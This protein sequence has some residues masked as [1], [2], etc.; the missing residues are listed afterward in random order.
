MS[1]RIIYGTA[2]TGKSTYI[3]QEI[4]EILNRQY[5]NEKEGR[6][7]KNIEANL[8]Q[9]KTPSISIKIITPEQ[10]S[11]TAERKLLDFA[12][13][14]SVLTAEV[15]TFNRMAYRILEEVGGKTKSHLSSSGR[16]MLLD[17]ILLTQKNDF[18]FLG[19]TDENVDMIATQLTELKKHNVSINNLKEITENMK[20]TYLKRK[21]QD[22][23]N[24]YE[25]YT[26]RIQKQ[27]ID[28]NDG[29][30][31]LSERLDDSIQFKNC[32][33]YLD[34]FVGFTL[35]EYAVLRK[36]IKYSKNVTITIC[37]D[38][39]DFNTNPAQDLFYSNKQT[40]ARLIKIANEENIKVEEAI[41]MNLEK[42]QLKTKLEPSNSKTNYSN[43]ASNKA[44]RFHTPELQHLSENMVTPFYTKYEKDVQNLSVF[45]AN[46]PYSE[47]EHV[48]IEITKL[49][50]EKHYRYEEIA[51][52][53]KDIATYGSLCKAIFR[54]Y[55]IPV[56]IDDEKD[57]S[58]NVLVKWMLSLLDIF[59][60][61]WSY[62]AVLGYIKTGFTNLEQYEISLLENY[63]LKWGLKGSKW[64]AKDW[65]FYDESEEE[66]QI[67]LHAKEQIIIPLLQFK[68]QLKGLKTVKQITQ[69]LYKFMLDNHIP[70]ILEEKIAHLQEIGELERANEYTTSWNIVMELLK[71]LIHILGEEQITF[72][73][74]SK[75]I[76]M[77][78]ESSHLGAIPGTADQV[79]MG[80]TDRSRSHKVKAVFIIGLNDGNFPS[81]HKDE[82][83][84]DDKDR[85]I[86]KE[87]GIELAKGTME[88]LYDDQ[89]NIYKAFTT[90]E[91]KLYLS[92]VSSDSEGKSL[93][94]SIMLNKIKRMFPTLH[95]ESDVVERKSEILLKNT[96]FDELL[97][98][99]RK[100]QEGEK[101]EP[102][103]F[104]VYRYYQNYESEKLQQSL[105]ALKYR[106]VPGRLEKANLEKLYSNTLKTSVSKLEQYE[107]CAFSYYLKYGLELKEQN[108]FQV[109]TID[110]GNFMHEVI[111]GFF[112]Y[113][114][115]HQLS[116]KELLAEQIQTVTEEIVA[117]KLTLKKY[118]IFQSIPKYRTLA[119]RLK[120]VIVR[121]MQYIV[122]SLKYSEFEVLGHELEFKQGKEYSPITF[123]LS[124]GKKVEITGKID[125]IDIAKTPDGNYIRIIDYKSSV[126]NID[127]NEVL[128]GLQLQLL[129]YLD[130][131]CK[132]EEVLP[133]GVF[134]FPLIDPILNCDK[135]VSEEKIREEL[136]KQFKM[137]GLILANVNVV[138]KM[139]TNLTS[140]NSNIVPAYVNKDGEVS[141]KSN[142]LNRKQFESLQAYM[143]KIIKQI[144]TE[145]LDGN[146]NIEPYYHVQNN[147]TPCEY[148]S[149]KSICQFNQTT[150]NSYRYITN[151]SK[152]YVLEQMKK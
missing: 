59:V 115:E 70:E 61:N 25:A 140:G 30:T 129:T 48:A 97:V 94:P 34:E 12:P 15:I 27:Y 148:C 144:S 3:F 75:V 117:E 124:N 100:F 19:K 56:F 45:L 98:Q 122:N 17:D 49:V 73:R 41:N 72:E 4:Q 150:P 105:Q 109:E 137:K 85:E 57:L 108:T 22:V 67:I 7:I 54:G 60:K 39:L 99:L 146:I 102:I 76:K 139:D 65:N 111:D 112:T 143:E 147:K 46:N 130:A 86:L 37:A 28:E 92:Y 33:V 40:V 127:L 151:A 104:Q 44:K 29:L 42:N 31:I 14:N 58:E 69:S 145:I 66:Q 81:N 24:I 78:F 82:G 35:Q 114:E 16:A 119:Q 121:S 32:D 11:F 134:Y 77:G 138:K 126:K 91:E 141:E 107:S 88:Q 106:N 63:S 10:F 149:Y 5:K 23:Y 132:M 128:A 26:T 20:D 9:T 62:E 18:T 80:D 95:E 79:I 133:A 131:T 110:T 71:E 1:L 55:Q 90:A 43:I 93:R 52:I 116:V 84:L 103:W 50:K 123:E 2:G 74:Y 101:I 51:I 68:D 113:L 89:F 13:S 83:F 64:Y 21:L 87:Q 118:D 53:T 36:L 96:T 135:Q 6:N 47:I 136:Q 38:N 142:T 125:R 120:K 8:K 152:E